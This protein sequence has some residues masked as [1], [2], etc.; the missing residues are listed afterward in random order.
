MSKYDILLDDY[1]SLLAF[2][3]HNTFSADGLLQNN[4]SRAEQMG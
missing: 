4:P 2:R 3:Y 1:A